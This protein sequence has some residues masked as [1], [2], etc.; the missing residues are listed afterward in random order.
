MQHVSL[1]EPFGIAVWKVCSCLGLHYVGEQSGK[2]VWEDA[3]GTITDEPQ[4]RILNCCIGHAKVWRAK[5]SEYY[6]ILPEHAKMLMSRL[7]CGGSLTPDNA[8]EATNADEQLPLLLELRHAIHC[9]QD[10]FSEMSE[11]YKRIL[12]MR[13]VSQA[14]CPRNSALA[15]FFM[16]GQQQVMNHASVIA[17]PHAHIRSFVFD[18]IYV[19]GASQEHLQQ[20]YAGVAPEIHKRH[21]IRLALK[22]AS[23]D[24]VSYLAPCDDCHE[25]VPTPR[26]F[27]ASSDLLRCA[28]CNGAGAAGVREAALSPP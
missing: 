17:K 7:P 27:Q 21:H 15:W 20:I 6:G 19:L 1:G 12:H 11:A 26:G 13:K 5:I 24:K 22:S 9:A 4:F 14:R 8:W 16:D 3:G 28:A 2:S 25:L 10:L 23:G 18:S